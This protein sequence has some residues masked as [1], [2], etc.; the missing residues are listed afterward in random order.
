MME[1][2]QIEQQ[3]DIQRRRDHSL[4]GAQNNPHKPL[5]EMKN[6]RVKFRWVTVALLPTVRIVNGDT[7]LLVRLPI[8]SAIAKRTSV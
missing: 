5:K 1:Y 7:R 4:R 8:L 2:P 3:I 6:L